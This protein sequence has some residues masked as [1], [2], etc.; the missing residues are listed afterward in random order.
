MLNDCWPAAS[1]WSFIDYYA[2]PK[3]MYYTFKRCAKPVIAAL[4]GDD[5][6]LAVHVCNDRMEAVQGRAS[7]YVC[8]VETGEETSI[9]EF[10]F[11]VGENCSE[12][13]FECQYCLIEPRINERSVILCD[14]T[15]DGDEDR[16]MFVPKRF[17]DL[18]I[19]YAEPCVIE[20]NED[21]I[22]LSADS[23]IPYAM[24]DLPYLL[25][26]NCFILKKGERKTIKK[27]K[28]Q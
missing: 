14:I 9:S 18:D 3:P 1:G 6:K 22:M 17:A 21:S 20:E 2:C 12:K 16:A 27:V 19:S 15:C 5:G 7:I 26:D 28:A 13:V 4:S 24:L 10:E 23:F 25:S 11:S 8:N